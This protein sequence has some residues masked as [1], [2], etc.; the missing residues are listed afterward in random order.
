MTNERKAIENLQY[1]TLVG[2]IVAQ[3]V[4]GS[5][6]IIGQC[7]YLGCNLI[8]LFRCFA[9]A[10]PKA[11]CVKDIACT[12]ITLGLIAIYFLK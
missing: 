9:L 3:C 4:I 1:I 12:A 10:R 2:L 7:I 8:S 5:A 6:Y 11:D